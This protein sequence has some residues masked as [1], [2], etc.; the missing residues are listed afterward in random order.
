MRITIERALQL[1]KVRGRISLY[2]PDLHH[3]LVPDLSCDPCS[4]KGCDSFL[5]YPLTTD[6]G[7]S[8]MVPEPQK[9]CVLLSEVFRGLVSEFALALSAL[10]KGVRDEPISACRLRVRSA[11]E[12]LFGD[13]F[14]KI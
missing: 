8:S 13:L 2:C 6:R 5:S 10:A 1:A 3:E 7:N 11:A 4:R 14:A 9:R 12:T